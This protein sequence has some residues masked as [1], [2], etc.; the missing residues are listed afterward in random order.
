MSAPGYSGGGFG[1]YPPPQP[2]YAPVA[3]QPEYGVPMQ[4]YNQGQQ[5]QVGAP[6]Q[7]EDGMWMGQVAETLVPVDCPPGLEYLTLIDQLIIKQKVEMLEALSGMMGMGF[8]TSNKYKIKNSL[9]QNVYKAKEDTDCCTR[10]VCGPARPF[11]MVITDNGDREVLHLQRPMR[12][13]S[14]C[15]PCC[16]Q[17]LE[18]CSPPGTT[19]GF[20]NQ[21]WTCIKPK[22]EITDGDGN[23]ALVILGPWCTYSCAGDVEFKIM[24]PDETVE[25]GRISKQWSGLLKEAFTDTD[26]FGITFPMDLD[27]R[28]KATLI[29]AAFLIDYMFF[30]KKANQENDGVGML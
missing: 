5:Q 7:G 28:A 25:V 29:G 16:L 1:G 21:C 22:F 18:V 23:V 24:T 19:I 30:E 6:L 9:G 17:S 8:E 11:D 27:V 10:I 13:Q 4:Q 2:G 14:C 20:V 15:F 12:C 26:N 3:Q